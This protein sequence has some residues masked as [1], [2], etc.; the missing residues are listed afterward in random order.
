MTPMCPTLSSYACDYWLGSHRHMNRRTRCRRSFVGGAFMH[1]L[2]G[3]WGL[4]VQLF[5]RNPKY[6]A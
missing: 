1:E 4:I 3:H 2:L 6:V 5:S